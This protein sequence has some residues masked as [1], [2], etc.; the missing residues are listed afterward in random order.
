M[1]SPEDFEIPGAVRIVTG[2]GGLPKL[3]IESSHSTAEVYLHGAHVSHFQKHGEDPLLFLSKCSEFNHH[4]PIRGGIPVIFPWFGARENSA[5]HGFARLTEWELVETA[6]LEEG[7]VRI[8]LQLPTMAAA[9]VDYFVTVSDSLTL[10]LQVRC[11]GE[12]IFTFENCLHSYF[13]VGDI[14]RTE[15][16]GLHQA[17]YL[18]QLQGKSFTDS[19]RS[20]SFTS[21]TNRIYQHTTSPVSI[22]DP[23]LGRVIR[24]EKSGSQST[25][26]WNPWID[27]SQ[28]MP[29]F[30]DHEY[31]TMLCVES[32][33]VRDYAVNI[34]RG[35]TAT[36]QVNISS[37]PLPPAP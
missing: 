1:N 24:V 16:H 21:E 32:G 35:E 19:E 31:L 26:V 37:E 36:L 6:V 17:C 20:L 33:N 28:R 15:V 27:K 12:R 14:S 23:V 18:D 25:V 9:T 5:F 10:E 34:S 4:K 11:I 7:A 29:D 22:V 3:L 8:Q 30:G 2:N 13:R